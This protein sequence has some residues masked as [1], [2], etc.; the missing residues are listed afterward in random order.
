M[1]NKCTIIDDIAISETTKGKGIATFLMKALINWV[2][3]KN[4][5]ELYLFAS[6]K[7]FNIYKK[8]GFKE[9]KFWIEQFQFKY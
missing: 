9:K 1:D 2:L 6:E 7:A 8:L 5:N 3:E 4:Q